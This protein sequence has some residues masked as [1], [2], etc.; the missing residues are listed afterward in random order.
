[1]LRLVLNTRTTAS[2]TIVL[3]LLLPLGGL[4]Q[5]N[6]NPFP[7]AH[8]GRALSNV[9]GGV[10]RTVE[11]IPPLQAAQQ[12]FAQ[13]L[14][15]VFDT[16]SLTITSIDASSVLLQSPDQFSLHA[17]D[18]IVAVNGQAVSS[19]QQLLQRLAGAASS[20]RP[21]SL[22]VETTASGQI[23]TLTVPQTI[24]TAIADA[25]AN[26]GGTVSRFTPNQGTGSQV[27]NG[28]NTNSSASVRSA[29]PPIQAALKIWGDDLGVTFDANSLTI[30][31]IDANSPLLQSATQF[32]LQVGDQITAINGQPITSPQQ[33][34][35]QLASAANSG[36]PVT[37]SIEATASGQVRTLTVPQPILSAIAD[38]RA[39]FGAT[40][41]TTTPSRFDSTQAARATSD[42]STT[43][44]GALVQDALQQRATLSGSQRTTAAAS[45][46]SGRFFT[47]QELQRMGL[48]APGSAGFSGGGRWISNLEL[49]R[50]GLSGPGEAG[51]PTT[52]STQPD[53]T[54]SNVTQNDA[55]R[56]QATAPTTSGG[57]W[58]SNQELRRL[59]LLGADD[60]NFSRGGTW[61]S[62]QELA[63]LGLSGPGEAGAPTTGSTQA[64]VT[65][66]NVN[67]NDAFRTQAAASTTSSGRWFSNQELRR[68]GLLGADDA[69]F[70]RG[71]TWIS[72]QELARLG[73]SGPG[74][75]GA[76]TT[77]NS[78]PDLSNVT[79][80]ES[81]T[82]P[83]TPATPAIP[84]VSRAIPATPAVPGRL[85]QEDDTTDDRTSGSQ[86]LP[87]PNTV[88]TPTGPRIALP[89]QGQG[90]S[91]GVRSGGGG[92]PSGVGAP[93]VRGGGAPMRGAPSGPRGG[94]AP[95]GG[96][97]AARAVPGGGAAAGAAVRATGS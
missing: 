5:V 82:Q 56:A 92:A 1:M 86:Q 61:I 18:Q 76:P 49:A 43:S 8:T 87:L 66:S 23:Q 12:I 24:L 85:N 88:I 21:V 38:A 51:A 54:P 53:L 3:G 45:G 30:A 95:R 50:L 73:L 96:G 14:G 97:G 58:F 72:S 2:G 46:T 11:N 35:Q 67:Q 78:T 10:G 60:A 37:L 75:A 93:G 9:P 94:G 19:P 83:A 89:G 62:S 32:S 55:F 63:R 90:P 79:T 39:N 40:V 27:T 29:T 41:R 48:I 91:Q 44:A 13:D 74:E 15:L 80:G 22:T 59:G 31:A 68:L 25:R 81:G 65:P 42:Q 70:S 34:L 36:R 52:G 6:D 77:G 57:R 71:G 16:G 26:F 4:A 84:G 28:T 17:G 47:N 20:G 33:L 69:N 64:D 7:P